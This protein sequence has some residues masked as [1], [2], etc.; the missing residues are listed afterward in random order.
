MEDP[1]PLEETGIVIV[2]CAFAGRLFF[3]T[4]LHFFCAPGIDTPASAHRTDMAGTETK[5][6]AYFFSCAA[7]CLHLARLVRLALVACLALLDYL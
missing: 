6:M 3:S 1:Q 5:L 7:S 2:Y 4:L